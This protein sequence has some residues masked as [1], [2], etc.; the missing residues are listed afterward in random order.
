MNVRCSIEM[1]GRIEQDRKPGPR[2]IERDCTP[3]RLGA[4]WKLVRQSATAVSARN[5]G[6]AVQDL[7]DIRIELFGRNVVV[8]VEGEID[9]VAI[10]AFR[11]AIVGALATSPSR[12]FV[13]LTEA[14]VTFIQAYEL[15]GRCSDSGGRTVVL[16]RD[17]DAARIMGEL[18]FGKVVCTQPMHGSAVDGPWRMSQ[19]CCTHSQNS[20]GR[21]GE[22]A[23]QD[24]VEARGAVRPSWIGSRRSELRSTS[25]TT[26]E[27]P[28]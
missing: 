15:I 9:S 13:D 10:D 23:N 11:A 27:W 22:V 14:T 26:C 4:Q 20:M 3:L 1:C 8:L 18:G 24:R 6:V 5:P 16:S 7:L 28:E 12:L 19:P 21:S 25:Q 2:T 17:A